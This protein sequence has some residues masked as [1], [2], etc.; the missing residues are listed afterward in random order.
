[1]PSPAPPMRV[2][3]DPLPITGLKDPEIALVIGW[4]FSLLS[5]LFHG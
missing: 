3:L 4:V 5:G 1:M 2:L